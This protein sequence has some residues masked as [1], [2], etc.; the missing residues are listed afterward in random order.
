MAQ[1]VHHKYALA[2]TLDVELPKVSHS[3]PESI[4]PVTALA[5]DTLEQNSAASPPQYAFSRTARKPQAWDTIRGG[6]GD[7]SFA[8]APL[9][10]LVFGCLVYSRRE[11]PVD[12]HS[13]ARLLEAS[14]YVSVLNY[15]GATALLTCH[16]G[17]TL[18]PIVF[19]A[20]VAR[21]LRSLAALK[22]EHG[23]RVFTLEYLLHSRTVFSTIST[24]FELGTFHVLT[25][26]LIL[27]W[28]LSPLGGQ[29]SLRV[30]YTGPL[31]TNTTH[32][33]TSLAFVSPFTNEGAGSP[34]SEPLVP[35]NSQFTA[36]ISAS[37][38]SKASA[39]DLYG[40]VKIPMYDILPGDSDWKAVPDTEDVIWSSLTGIPIYE[41]PTS[42]ASRFTM[43]TGYM[44]TACKV[45]G[46]AWNLKFIQSI[47]NLTGENGGWSGANF[48]I[49]VGLM[50]TFAPTYFVFRS[51]AFGAEYDNPK[52]L[53]VA[54]CSVSMNYVEVQVGCNG[55]TCQPEAVRPSADPADHP[56]TTFAPALNSSQLTPLNGL[57]QR[58]E[59]YLSFWKNF[60]NA[61][62]PS[63]GCDTTTC[64]TSGVE[65]YLA[66]PD[67]PF[68]F[69][70]NPIIWTVGDDLVSQRFAQL[71][72]TYWIN[73]IGPLIVSG[74]FTNLTQDSS[75]LLQNF[76]TDSSIGSIETEVDVIMCSKAWLA[77]LLISSLVLMLSAIAAAV[78]TIF[79]RGPDI[80]DRFSS[81]LRDNSYVLDPH[82]SSMEDS[83]EQ[84]RRLGNVK[85]R[86][87]DV[88]PNADIGYAA[89]ALMNGNIPPQRLSPQRLYR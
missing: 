58:D 17:P 5:T 31:Y 85:V 23:A 45:S 55:S 39:Q 28:A 40:N 14:K 74:N 47:Y 73:T 8:I 53:T 63:V 21:F 24:P 89:I 61:T 46:Q 84:S 34:S 10:F 60:I 76:N 65:G 50:D 29:A 49:E 35:I 69:S 12:Q 77:I 7:L 30:V 11:Q 87:G 83:F 51:L 18:F 62:D 81:L 19:A 2:N 80:L 37:A 68:S 52:P 67:S 1:Q 43:N 13:N 75:S 41:L 20:I 3:Q 22:L 64:T 16:K 25:P 54:N 88:Q 15:I 79:R 72:N 44:T 42:G 9:C 48:A 59:M 70:D 32:N 36:F 6:L 38:A 57:G 56:S 71:V 27:L 86:L 82:H 66:N 4:S 26:L 33:F 78:F